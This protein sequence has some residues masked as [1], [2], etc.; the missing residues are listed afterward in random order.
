LRTIFCWMR[1]GRRRARQQRWAPWNLESIH[2]IDHECNDPRLYLYNNGR[3]FLSAVEYRRT[4]TDVSEMLS[5]CS[6]FI[7]EISHI[8]SS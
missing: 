4:S 2:L 6:P 1:A 5:W 3:L 7:T 8:R